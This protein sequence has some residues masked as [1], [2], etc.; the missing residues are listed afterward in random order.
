MDTLYTYLMNG[1]KGP[2]ISDHVD[3]PTK[4]ASETFPYLV[5]PNPTPPSPPA[6]H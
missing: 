1:G 4:R 5:E 3:G 6:H 2:R